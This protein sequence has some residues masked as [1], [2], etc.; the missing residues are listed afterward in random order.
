[1]TEQAIK[2]VGVIGLGKMGNP[3][4]RHLVAAGYSVTGYDINAGAANRAE[5]NGTKRVP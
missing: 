1:M 5:K 4:A 2:T 3:I